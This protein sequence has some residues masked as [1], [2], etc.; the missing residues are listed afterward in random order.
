MYKRISV[1]S[2]V[3]HKCHSWQCFWCAAK[4]SKTDRCCSKRSFFLSRDLFWVSRSLV[5]CGLS[6]FLGSP[7]GYCCGLPTP[8]ETRDCMISYLGSIIQKS[9]FFR[10]CHFDDW[11]VLLND[12]RRYRGHP[13]LKWTLYL[14]GKGFTLSFSLLM[15]LSCCSDQMKSEQIFIKSRFSQKMGRSLGN[16][17]C[18]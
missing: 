5:S 11:I 3:W 6:F 2:D 10:R 14:R 15:W 18:S 7:S 1:E 17:L 4:G 16:F 8:P 9:T 13:D 12:T